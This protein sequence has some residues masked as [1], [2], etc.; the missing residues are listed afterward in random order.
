M[1]AHDIT[2]G[3]PNYTSPVTITSTGAVLGTATAIYS[4]A[5]ATVLNFGTVSA[6]GNGIVFA[7]GGAVTN[8]GGGAGAALISGIFGIKVSGGS[9]TVTNA[10]TI[11]GVGGSG[12]GILLAA[13]GTVS[14]GVSAMTAALISGTAYGIGVQG[15]AA[16]ISNAATI[17]GTGA[18]SSGMQ[19]RVGGAVSNGVG[20]AAAALISGVNYGVLVQ[21][22]SGNVTNAGTIRSTNASGGSTGVFLAKRG[23]VGNGVN[24]ATAALITA[25]VSGIYVTGCGRHRQQCRHDRHQAFR[26]ERRR[27]LA[28]RRRPYRQR[29]QRHHGGADLGRAWRGSRG[30]GRRRQQCR[31][32][33]RHPNR[34]SRHPAEPRWQYHQRCGRC[35]GGAG[36]GGKAGILV[37]GAAGT[38]ANYGTVVATG[39]LGTGVWFSGSFNDT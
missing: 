5:S 35:D 37:A 7:T 12:G 23:Y 18:F 20:G 11:L 27:H 36:L 8:G 22:A 14:N 28:E 19:L 10:G 24:G 38:V 31:H 2:L 16:T 29:R 13:G 21:G 3:S 30:C 4:L 34:R 1:I 15:A 39:S 25:N 26:R 32:D 9:G 6:P 33:H 17:V